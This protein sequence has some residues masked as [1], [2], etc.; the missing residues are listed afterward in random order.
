MSLYLLDEAA[1]ELGVCTNTLRGHIAR[2]EVAV[3]QVGH[4]SRRKHVR[5]PSFEIDA[6][7]ARHLCRSSGVVKNKF[8]GLS[9]KSKGV[10]FA[11]L[12]AKR[13]S[14]KR[15]LRKTA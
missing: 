6:Y 13:Q 7:K 11:D 9:L 12:L 15:E 10:E 2:G 4:G 8:S 1:K 5:I 3:I 14:E